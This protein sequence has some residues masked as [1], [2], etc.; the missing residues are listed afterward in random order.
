M[1]WN[2]NDRDI[3]DIGGSQMSLTFEDQLPMAFANKA[4]FPKEVAYTS[5]MDKWVDI[6]DRSYQTS[7]EMAIIEATAQEV[8]SQLP[9]GTK[10][11]DLGAANSMKFEPYVREFLKQGKTCTYVALDIS[12]PALIDQVNRAKTHFPTVRCVGVWGSFKHGDA[13]FDQIPSARLFLSLGSI[14]FNAPDQMC[15][16]RCQEFLHHFSPHDRLI[17]GQDGPARTESAKSHASY[18]TKE[19]DAFFTRYLEGIQHHAGIKADAKKAWSYKSMM[20]EGMH[21][22]E[23]VSRQDM[24]CTRFDNLLVKTGT[25]YKMFPSWK[26][27]E[28]NISEITK[29]VGLDIQTLSKAEN[30][31]MR[32]YLIKAN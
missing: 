18:N 29:T 13:Y 31:G 22:F 21:Y 16:E 14:F 9:S 12:H 11:I 10:I 4:D 25:T 26:R 3:I 2:P 15:K 8:V 20:V 7:D 24:I 19:Y 27:D 5:G 6:A 32:Q 1:E 17:V 23:V 28:A 30:S